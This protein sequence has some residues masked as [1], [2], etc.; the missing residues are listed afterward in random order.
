[1][2]KPLT[3]LTKKDRPF[4]WTQSLQKAFESIK[5]KL[6]QALVLPCPSFDLPSI[7]TTDASKVAVAAI[8][9]RVQNGVEPPT[10]YASSSSTLLLRLRC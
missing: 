1:V 4:I 5:D 6:R 7:L 9:S 2:V 3:E 10:A 8:L